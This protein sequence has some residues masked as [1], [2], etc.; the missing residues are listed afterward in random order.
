MQG[1]GYFLSGPGEIRTETYSWRVP[2]SLEEQVYLRATLWYRRMADSQA[3]ILG[4]EKRPHLLVSQDE[5]LVRI[6]GK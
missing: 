4:I 3:E 6:T 5:K 1:H 2:D